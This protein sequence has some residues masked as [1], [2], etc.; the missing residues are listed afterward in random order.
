MS[1][2]RMC[3]NFVLGPC[4]KRDLKTFGMKLLGWCDAEYRKMAGICSGGM[5]GLTWSH[6]LEGGGKFMPIIRRNQKRI[7][8]K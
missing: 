7:V 8:N 2:L 5:F 1:F 4:E 3:V 6:I